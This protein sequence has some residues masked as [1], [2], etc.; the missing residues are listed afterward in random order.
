MLIGTH[1]G[2][3][4]TAMAE[5]EAE[6]YE[7]AWRGA[8]TSE[9][10]DKLSDALLAARI[11]AARLLIGRASHDAE[12][13]NCLCLHLT[14]M[15]SARRAQALV[16]IADAGWKRADRA[17]IDEVKRLLLGDP[18][19]DVR[20]AAAYALTELVTYQMDAITRVGAVLTLR[21][22][23]TTDT[24]EEV[25]TAAGTYYAALLE[26]GYI[27]EGELT[28]TPPESVAPYMQISVWHIVIAEIQQA[29]ERAK[30][31]AAA[32]AAAAAAARA[33]RVSMAKKVA[34]VVVGV[35]AV[36]VGVWAVGRHKREGQYV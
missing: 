10:C 33:R 18:R 8:S 19:A 9:L 21:A 23:A 15:D 25:A 26:D 27:R 12:A 36:G 3:A 32:E 20:K 14:A 31:K 17:T 30:A 11:A 16:A 34:A 13:T 2:D 1:F 29:W 28:E 35:A 6:I 4:G 24:D 22:A 5:D 7:R